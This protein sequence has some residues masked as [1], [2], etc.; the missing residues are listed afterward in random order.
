MHTNNILRNHF[1]NIFIDLY[2]EH[3]GESH[4]GPTL[5]QQVSHE[6]E[7]LVTSIFN[8]HHK[9][10]I[11]PDKMSKDEIIFLN[12]TIKKIE[13]THIRHLD[14]LSN[15]LKIIQNSAN[16]R[17]KQNNEDRT[18]M[19]LGHLVQF[20]P[21]QFLA[22]LSP[23]FYQLLTDMVK[24]F[25]GYELQLHPDNFPPGITDYT[26]VVTDAECAA[27]GSELSIETIKKLGRQVDAAIEKKDHT[28]LE[29]M[30]IEFE[31][32]TLKCQINRLEKNFPA[33]YGRMHLVMARTYYFLKEFQIANQHFR[34]AWHKKVEFSAEDIR[35]HYDTSIIMGHM[36]GS[37]RRAYNRT[38]DFEE[39]VQPKNGFRKAV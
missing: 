38:E 36:E 30:V 15:R 25:D 35:Q 18:R 4:F 12:S 9:S 34:K 37:L 13:K 3:F 19:I 1:L 14:D 22:E 28:A 8:V 5:H 16:K 31:D 27:F 6:F 23:F 32:E 10:E 29:K 20:F 2:K 17:A 7:Q 33:A 24:R 39:N 21:D 26:Y 11:S